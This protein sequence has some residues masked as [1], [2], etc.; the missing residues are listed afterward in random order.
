MSGELVRVLRVTL[1]HRASLRFEPKS[2]TML[3]MSIWRPHVR[4]NS[5]PALSAPPAQTPRLENG[6]SRLERV[7]R[8]IYSRFYIQAFW[9]PLSEQPSRA[10]VCRLRVPTPPTPPLW[11]SSLGSPHRIIRNQF[12]VAVSV[13]F[14]FVVDDAAPA[15]VRVYSVY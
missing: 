1:I 14:V 8:P 5:L 12:S 3:L 15:S 13:A 2:L 4:R 7:N 10:S 6:E 9:I 11:I